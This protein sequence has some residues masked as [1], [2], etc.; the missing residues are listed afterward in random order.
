MFEI[1]EVAAVEATGS[2]IGNAISAVKWIAI[3]ALLL[4]ALAC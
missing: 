4:S 3:D 2:L 1:K